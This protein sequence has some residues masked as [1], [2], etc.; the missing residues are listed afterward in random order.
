MT[1]FGEIMAREATLITVATAN[2]SN[3]FSA[4]R[5]TRLLASS[6]HEEDT[7]SQRDGTNNGLQTIIIRRVTILTLHPISLMALGSTRPL[8][9]MNTRN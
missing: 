8:T 6:I 5:N 2:K 1:L 3:V 9:E 7:S 4:S